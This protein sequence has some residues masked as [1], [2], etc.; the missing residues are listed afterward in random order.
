MRACTAGYVRTSGRRYAAAV[1][2]A[3]DARPCP[4]RG[5]RAWRRGAALTLLSLAVGCA[6]PATPVPAAW[7]SSPQRF[8]PWEERPRELGPLP[9]EVGQARPTGYLAVTEYSDITLTNSSFGSELVDDDYSVP[10]IGGGAQFKLGGDRVDLGLEFLIA[11]SGRGNVAAFASGGGGTVV[12]VDIDLLIWDLYGGP[13][14]SLWVT[15]N[16]RIYGAA[17]PLVQ[18]ADYDQSAGDEA[19]EEDGS[20]FGTGWYGRVGIDFFTTWHTTI[21][22]AA[23]FFD[24]NIELDNSF[25][26]LDALGAEYAFTVTTGW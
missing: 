10:A 3:F 9:W 16:V 8:P 11:F 7:S 23:R 20:G 5:S 13:F 18:F 25:A 2:D 17:G 1:T 15:E 19:Y 24:T 4:S 21:G 12:A 26:E 14:L 6:A 22:I